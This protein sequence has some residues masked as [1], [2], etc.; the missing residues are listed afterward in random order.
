VLHRARCHLARRGHPF[1]VTVNSRS[2][3][4]RLPHVHHRELHTCSPQ[5]Q[6]PQ[7]TAPAISRG[8]DP[9]PPTGETRCWTA[10]A[11]LM[12]SVLPLH[13]PSSVSEL[14]SGSNPPA[15]APCTPTSTAPAPWYGGTTAHDALPLR[16][17]WLAPHLPHALL[18]PLMRKSNSVQ[19]ATNCDAHSL[20]CHAV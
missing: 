9:T 1:R 19:T 11:S 2:S 5:H 12:P 3:T 18:L 4:R 7:H 16:C 8:H 14:E 10:C 13:V 20:F 17:S 6:A 15:S